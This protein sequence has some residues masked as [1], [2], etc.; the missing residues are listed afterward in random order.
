[1]TT[2]QTV[3][4]ERF[5][6][7]PARIK[8][9]RIDA[10]GYPVPWF[11]EWRDGQPDFRIIRRGAVDV[12]C[13]RHLCWICG[14][15][16]GRLKSFV[17][18]PMCAVNRVSS[19]PPSHLPCATFAATH[20]PFLTHP[21]ARRREEGLPEDKIEAPGIMNLR[22]PGVALVWT[23]LRYKKLYPPGGGVLFDIGKPHGLAW[24]AHGRRASRAECR[25]SIEGGLPALREL[26]DVDDGHALLDA[27]LA[28]AI[29]LLPGDE[30]EDD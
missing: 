11:V 16:L 17:I 23:T 6:D 22:N 7:A 19:E 4:T 12:A 29:K 9:L 2:M 26:A 10:R 3:R 25:A 30:D 18:G 15:E 27:M 1:M 13:E 28:R 14:G 8:R 24:Y 21:L 5:P 20:C